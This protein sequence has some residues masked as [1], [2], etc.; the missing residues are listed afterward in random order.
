MRVY[1]VICHVRVCKVCY[2]VC[3]YVVSYHLRECAAS[4]HYCVCVVG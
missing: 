4:Y 2:H 3:W 1:V